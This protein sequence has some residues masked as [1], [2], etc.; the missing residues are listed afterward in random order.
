MKFYNSKERSE[1]E[2]RAFAGLFQKQSVYFNDFLDISKNAEIFQQEPQ[3]TLSFWVREYYIMKNSLPDETEFY[4]WLISEKANETKP[5]GYELL[6][7]NFMGKAITNSKALLQLKEYAIDD[8]IRNDI[9]KISLNTPLDYYHEMLEVLTNRLTESNENVTTKVVIEN[10][11]RMIE[12]VKNNQYKNYIK[13]GIHK[14]DLH[15]GGFARGELHTFAGRAGMGKTALMNQLMCNFIDN[16]YKVGVISLEMT[17]EQLMLRRFASEEKICSNKLQRGEVTTDV[18]NNLKQ[19]GTK[20]SKNLFLSDVPNQTVD[21][22]L[23]R[24]SMWIAQHGVDILMIDYL[25]LI[26]SLPKNNMRKDEII[27]EITWKLK[28]FAKQKNIAII[29]ISQLNRKSDQREDKRPMISDLRESGNIEQDS[30]TVGLLHRPAYY[31][32]DYKEENKEPVYNAAGIEISPEEYCE[33][34]LAKN[35]FGKQLIIRL[36]FK[37]EYSMFLPTYT[38]DDLRKMRVNRSA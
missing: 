29:L 24:A 30:A 19:K 9:G 21:Q 11:I 14:L 38:L 37:P 20:L 35:R 28:T 33:L 18:L 25:T 23:M 5:K 26:K 10:T 16:G 27:G 7:S 3:K 17:S 8:K 34:D 36:Q 13:S 1:L 31:G 15:T 32:V 6:L 4:G 2:K 12:D 22:I